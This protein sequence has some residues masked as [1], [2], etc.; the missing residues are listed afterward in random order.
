MVPLYSARVD[1]LKT[2][3]VVVIVCGSCQHT[4]EISPSGLL[5]GLGLQLTDRILDLEPHFRCRPCGARKQAT[6]SVKWKTAG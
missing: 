4:A 5:H 3:D 6:I 1:D 2:G